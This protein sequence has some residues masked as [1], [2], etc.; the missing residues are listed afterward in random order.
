MSKHLGEES[1]VG[2]LRGRV[3]E[4]CH[5]NGDALLV[6]GKATITRDGASVYLEKDVVAYGVQHVPSEDLEIGMELN[7]QI[8]LCTR[9]EVLIAQMVSETEESRL[10]RVQNGGI[11][12]FVCGLD[13]GNALEGPSAFVTWKISDDVREKIVQEQRYNGEAKLV[14]DCISEYGESRVFVKLNDKVAV[15]HFSQPGLHRIYARIAYC[16]YDGNSVT[17]R[18]F[19]FDGY[20]RG[21]CST[22]LGSGVVQVDVG[23]DVFDDKPADFEYVNSWFNTR[24][25]NS[26]QHAMR[27]I[28]AYTFFPLWMNAM[29]GVI[30][31]A[32]LVWICILLLCGM[33]G[34]N[35]K[36]L[37]SLDDDVH[38][39][40]IHERLRGSIFLPMCC[41]R[42]QYFLFLLSPMTMLAW[43]LLAQFGTGKV[44]V[45]EFVVASYFFS[46]VSAILT[47]VV[48]VLLL[49]GGRFL[50]EMWE[51]HKTE[52]AVFARGA[53]QKPKKLV[54]PSS[55]VGEVT[56]T[57]A[58][59][60]IK[61]HLTKLKQRF[62]HI[63]R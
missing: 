41:G 9:N 57:A 54:M 17:S 59:S 40:E 18:M 51:K 6:I 49:N 20:R 39:E 44:S 50:N 14:I 33:K 19:T 47:S 58:L 13:G 62:C 42:R 25:R 34:I 22:F 4:M 23:E 60:T 46:G 24:S 1:L 43:L 53:G 7:F 31:V 28:P 16:S 45:P 37:F 10:R 35:F 61:L 55:G 8:S 36:P 21:Y 5:D 38:T 26:C 3:T 56:N 52:S 2:F 27:R 63:Y 11:E 32:R 15:V 12:I 29:H 30:F 48:F